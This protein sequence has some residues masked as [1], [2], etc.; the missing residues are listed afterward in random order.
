MNETG[1]GVR[2]QGSEK[3]QGIASRL[4]FHVS[5]GFT[6]IEV[7]LAMAILAAVLG[8]LYASFFNAEESIGRAEAVRDDTDLARALLQGALHRFGRD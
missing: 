8:T 3:K 6:L 1:S 2:G 4:T 7:L 5:R